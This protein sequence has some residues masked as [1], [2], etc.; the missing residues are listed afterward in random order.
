MFNKTNCNLHLMLYITDKVEVIYK[1]NEMKLQNKILKQFI[2]CFCVG[3]GE[4]N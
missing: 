1:V 2:G 4:W 3:G